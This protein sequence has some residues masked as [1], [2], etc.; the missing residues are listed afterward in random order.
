M[1]IV[2]IGGSG[3]I[4][5]KLCKKLTERGHDAVAASPKSGVNT[6]TGEGLA[7]VLSAAQV[8]VDVSNA[9]NWEDAAVMKFFDTSTRN[10]LAAEAKAGVSHHVALSVVGTERLQESGY[11]RAK[12]VQENLIAAS[13]SPYTIVRA[14]QFFEFL[15]GIAQ[16]STEGQVVRLPSALMQP[17]SAN[18]VAAALADYAPG[19]ALNRIVEIAGPEAM[20]I[21]EAVRRFLVATGDT[22]RV[23]TDANAPYYGLK[24]SARALT[25]DKADRLAPTNLD[26]WLS[27]LAH[28]GAATV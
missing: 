27:Q 7:D 14:T 20:G 9:P 1:K 4:G 17:M 21:D 22:R 25:P 19:R 12:L 15:G 13:K 18:D 10:L 5:S 26:A 16:A 3:L 6:I 23:I 11:F 8:V 2:V 28:A 24:V